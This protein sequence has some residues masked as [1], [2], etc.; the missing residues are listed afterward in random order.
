MKQANISSYRIAPRYK[1]GYP[2]PHKYG[3]STEMDKNNGSTQWSYE[4]NNEMVRL[5]EYDTFRG[6]GK[7]GMATMGHN[8]I[9][10]H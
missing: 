4:N 8:N 6:L 9:L 2:V 10:S 7:Y 3:E 5:D 1:Y